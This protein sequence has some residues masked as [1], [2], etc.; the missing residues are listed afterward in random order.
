M[1]AVSSDHDPF[2][3]LEQVAARQEAEEKARKAV[4][5][6]R[7]RLVLGKDAK[8]VFFATLALRVRLEPDWGCPTMAVDGRT[9][10]YGPEFV[11]GLSG[12]ELVG[13]VCHETMH[14]A[15]AHHARRSGR[16]AS[17]F[18]V[19]CDLSINPLL[20]ESGFT[21]PKSRLMPG[22]GSYKDLPKG[23][24]AEEYYTLLP[25]PPE[26][27]GGDKGGDDPGGCGGVRDPGDGSPSDAQDQKADWE[28]AA[29]VAESAAKSRGTMPA[30]LARMVDEVLRPPADWRA[31]LREF[32]SSAA[33]NDF[34]WSRPNRRYIAQGLY[35]P[36]LHSEEL[37]D[38]LVLVDTS[39]S[40]GKQQLDSFATELN[41]ILDSFDCQATVVYHDSE[42]Q[43]V[44]EHRSSDGPLVLEPKGGGGTSH[45]WLNEWINREG[46]SPACIVALTDLWS[47]FGPDPGVPTL[48]AVTGDNTNAPFGQVVNIDH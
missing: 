34:S 2:A 32:V 29:A 16:D 7:T 9:M 14:L 40:I 15:L 45:A 17:Q 4:T 21:L 1:P 23:L 24:S 5:V 13:V 47:D 38:V 22:E 42:V 28:A 43:H 31:I 37:G 39:G 19:A 33:K 35:L 44:Q 46:K 48:W 12:D 8:S 3:A 41:G 36:G 20:E 18:N 10:F 6:A 30:G 25:K 26:G 11:N 27:Q